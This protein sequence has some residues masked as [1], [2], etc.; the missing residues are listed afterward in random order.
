MA[1]LALRAVGTAVGSVFGPVG[2]A[3]GSAL[4]A[5]GGYMLDQALIGSTRTIEGARLSSAQPM[6]ADEG[7]PVPRIYGYS[8]VPG[9]VIWATRLVETVDETRT[10][11]KKRRGVL[12]RCST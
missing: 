6:S 4:G 8:R 11:A 12:F 9:S 1:T 7:H 3:I 2:A 10:G 5:T